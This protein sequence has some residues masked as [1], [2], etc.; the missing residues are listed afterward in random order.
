MSNIGRIKIGFI[1]FLKK[2]DWVILLSISA[3]MTFGLVTMS[4]FSAGDSIFWKQLILIFIAI[5]LFIVFSFFVEN[6]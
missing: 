4:T 2:I 1:E 3:L 5:I 6:F